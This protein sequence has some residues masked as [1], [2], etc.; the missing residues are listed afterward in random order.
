MKRSLRFRIS[1]SAGKKINKVE[2]QLRKRLLEKLQEYENKPDL[3]AA[4]LKRL[5]DTKDP[6]LYRIRMGNYRVVGSIE[7]GFF[8]V[9]D[10]IHRRDL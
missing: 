2:P 5:A 9:L 10:F 1:R 7:G 3:L 6:V 8:N 4:D